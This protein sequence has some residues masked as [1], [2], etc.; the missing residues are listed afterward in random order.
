VS[1]TTVTESNPNPWKRWGLPLVLLLIIL[2]IIGGAYYASHPHMF[3]TSAT[4]TPTSTPTPQFTATPPAS[5]TA[6]PTLG[7]TATPRP[8][9]TGTSAAGPT[10]TP[11]P[12]KVTATPTTQST[13]PAAGGVQTGPISYPQSKVNHV[14]QAANRGDSSFTY[15]LDPTQVVMNDLPMFGFKG[16]FTVVSPQPA[17]QPT[18]TPYTNTAGKMETQFN[19]KYQGK[20]YL[21]ILDQPVQQGAKG[22]WLITT[23]KPLPA[24]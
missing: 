24:A 21:I 20:T 17:P 18:A 14:Q 15:Y 6:T 11:V 19:V 9:P 2:V 22:I 13:S 5:P 7:P 23:I 1:T 8:G 10:G 3:G 16:G 4:K 12:A